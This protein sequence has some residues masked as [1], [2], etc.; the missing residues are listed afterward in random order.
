MDRLDKLSIA[1]IV[2]LLAGAAVLVIVHR[3]EKKP[4][5]AQQRKAVTADDPAAAAELDRSAKLIRNLIEGGGLEQADRLA[6]EL[7][8]K[9][10]YHGEARMLLG[11]LLMRKQQPVAAMHEYKQAIELNPDYLDRK[12]PLFQGKKMKVAVGEAL[13][14]IEA[15]LKQSPGDASLK[16]EKKVIY[17][18]Y[19][20]IAGS[21]G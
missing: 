1:V 6:R 17:Y 11:D 5:L 4:G 8:G 14:E 13:A 19:R 21:C 3:D 20:K 12:T 7:T 2:I 15:R 10:P 18:L 16:S 9:Y